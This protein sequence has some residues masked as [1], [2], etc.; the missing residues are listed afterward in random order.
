MFNNSKK[1]LIAS[2]IEEDETLTK[3]DIEDIKKMLNKGGEI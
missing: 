3:E 1:K 2:L